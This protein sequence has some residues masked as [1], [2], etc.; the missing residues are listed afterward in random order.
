[1]GFHALELGKIHQ[2]KT[3]YRNRNMNRRSVNLRAIIVVQSY[4]MSSNYIDKNPTDL[5]QVVYF[6]GLPTSC[7]KG[8]QLSLVTTRWNRKLVDNKF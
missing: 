7:K 1:M 8:L 2:K 4:T 5:L 3:T 6:T